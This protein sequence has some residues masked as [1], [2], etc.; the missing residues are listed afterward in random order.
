MQAD[1]RGANPLCF[2]CN[3][4]SPSKWCL[5]CQQSSRLALNKTCGA[6]S[7]TGAQHA[8][9]V[10]N[11]GHLIRCLCPGLRPANG[12]LA[13]LAIGTPLLCA[14]GT[15]L[16]ER[17]APRSVPRRHHAGRAGAVERHGLPASRSGSASGAAAAAAGAIGATSGTFTLLSLYAANF[18]SV[19]GDTAEP[20]DLQLTGLRGGVAVPGCVPV[21]TS[22][23]NSI[24]CGVVNPCAA[25]RVTFSGCEDIDTLRVTVSSTS[26]STFWC[27]S[28]NSI[29]VQA[30]SSDSSISATAP[31]EGVDPV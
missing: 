23:P 11:T 2:L 24:D 25:T 21:S 1:C 5:V 4:L 20:D 18:N 16:S 7:P 19:L 6:P 29:L 30:C 15:L 9:P 26:P 27:I 12:A 10:A 22:L 28:L 31:F 17:V 13:L 3:P 8:I 14:L